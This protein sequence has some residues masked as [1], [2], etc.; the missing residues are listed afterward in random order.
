MLHTNIEPYFARLTCA[1]LASDEP[2]EATKSDSDVSLMRK[3]ATLKG[4]S[5]GRFSI[6]CLY[7]KRYSCSQNPH[8]LT[9]YESA[10]CKIKSSP[11]PF[12]EFTLMPESLKVRLKPSDLVGDT[13]CHKPPKT[14][15]RVRWRDR[16][17]LSGVLA[18]ALGVH[19]VAEVVKSYSK[20]WVKF[21]KA[22]KIRNGSIRIALASLAKP[23][24]Q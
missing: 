22:T 12:V 14:L 17:R 16:S 6:A 2:A 15:V 3:F 11:I 1:F 4:Q 21:N 9:A 7:R 5:A 13:V 20:F 19:G 24:P 18:K 8:R 10:R 23:R